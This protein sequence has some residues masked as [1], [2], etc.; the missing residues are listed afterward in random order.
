MSQRW[1]AADYDG[2][3]ATFDAVVR[4]VPD[5]CTLQC[6]DA[7]LFGIM[8]GYAAS[9][10]CDC[11]NWESARRL[12]VRAAS[13]ADRGETFTTRSSHLRLSGQLA[14]AEGDLQRSIA[15]HRNALDADRKNGQLGPVAVSA[16]FY[17][18]AAGEREPEPALPYAEYGLEIA[19]RFYPGDK[20]ARL[21]LESLD[22]ILGVRGAGAARDAVARAR[23]A[24]LG[25]RDSLFLDLAE[26]KIT[27][28]TGNHA[29]AFERA[30]A[31][32]KQLA[33]LGMSATAS[34][35]ELTAIESCA[36]LGQ[37]RRARHR[38]SDVTEVIVGAESR[39][40]ARRLGTLLALRA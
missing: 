17:A 38:L 16:V 34:D 32:A 18:A 39:E 37:R 24:G 19:E 36:R 40:R 29:A 26:S 23:R 25:L 1:A 9:M 7:I 11:G 14:R 33:R 20:F 15:E 12:H 2:M 31:V 10:E 30:E 28:R 4:A 22:V 8:L 6:G 21:T 35:A 5:E 27:A 13:I 3:R